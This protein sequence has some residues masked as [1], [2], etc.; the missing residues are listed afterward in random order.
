MKGAEVR[1]D[2]KQLCNRLAERAKATQRANGR[3]WYTITNTINAASADIY[4][5]D[6]IGEWGVSASDFAAEIS[7]LNVQDVNLHINSPGGLVH[8]GLAIYEVI[9]QHPAKWTG[10]VDGVAASAASFL[11]CACDTL[12][13]GKRAKM[14]IHDAEGMCMGDA[15]AM[16]ETADLLDLLS[17]TAAEI[18]AERAGGTPDEWRTLMRAGTVNMGTWLSA[19]QAIERGLAD[20]IIGA[21]A[22]TTPD[23][24]AVEE[25][26]GDTQ[27]DQPEDQLDLASLTAL[28]QEV[29]TK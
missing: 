15:A 19:D 29:F 26:P 16:R 20:G 22:K 18:Y 9:R 3:G 13:M 1:T 5:Y 6:E 24:A 11:A 14:M 12:L 10:M 27:Q 4:I 21:D 2:L 7:Q 28:M 17:D 23:A 8:E 25:Q